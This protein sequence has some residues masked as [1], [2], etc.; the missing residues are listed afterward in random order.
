MCGYKY[1]LKQAVRK[2]YLFQVC[3]H[4][5]LLADMIHR[6]NDLRPIL[7]TGCCLIMDESHKLLDT[8]R[9]MT[10][11]VFWR[12]SSRRAMMSLHPSFGSASASSAP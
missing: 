6:D 3:N 10:S 1:F 5:L 2:D 4:N 9:Q 7:P 12:S 8:A 11:T